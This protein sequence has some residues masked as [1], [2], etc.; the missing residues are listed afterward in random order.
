MFIDP[1][2]HFSKQA[3]KLLDPYVK[4]ER[5]HLIIVLISVLDQ[6][7]HGKSSQQAKRL[8]SSLV[9]QKMIEGLHLK[10]I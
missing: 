3:L 6:A 2:C 9:N 7:N 4:V 1:V 8:L 10:E 5:I